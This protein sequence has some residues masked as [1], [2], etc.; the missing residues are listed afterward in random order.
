M[1]Q[2]KLIFIFHKQYYI[3]E[4]SSIVSGI[5]RIILKAARKALV[6]TMLD[7]FNIYLLISMHKELHMYQVEIS[8]FPLMPMQLREFI[9]INYSNLFKYFI[10]L[11]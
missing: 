9:L 2:S 7:E 11:S 3:S 4:N 1:K 8:A 6:L 10:S 5:F